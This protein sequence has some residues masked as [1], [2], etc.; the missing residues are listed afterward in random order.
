MALTHADV[1]M[2]NRSL[3]GVGDAFA[4]RNRLKEAQRRTDLEAEYRKQM[5]QR[6]MQQ[7]RTQ[8]ERYQAQG[9]HEQRMEAKQDAIL[10]NAQFTQ[11][12]K[13][14]NEKIESIQKMVDEG[15]MSEED[16]SRAIKDFYDTFAKTQELMRDYS[17]LG[18]YKSSNFKVKRGAKPAPTLTPVEVPPTGALTPG[19]HFVTPPKPDKPVKIG[20]KEILTPPPPGS[21]PGTLPTRST[22][23]LFG[24]PGQTPTNATP[25]QPTIKLVRDPKTGKLVPAK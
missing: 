11:G 20:S 10:K 22:E 13:S 3:E 17:L 15:S 12:V 25:A 23:Y 18:A 14:M 16:G 19:G 8:Q 6:D 21:P 7:S 2:L 4:E 5:I 1:A 24:T 9:A